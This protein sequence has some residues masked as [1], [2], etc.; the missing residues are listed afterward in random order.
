MNCE[1]AGSGPYLTMIHGAGNNLGIWSKQVS[2]LAGH[3]SVLTYDIRGNGASGSGSYQVTPHILVEDLRSLLEALGISSS[4]VLGHS[5]GA[6][7]AIRFYFDHPQMVDAIVICNSIMGALRSQRELFEMR[8]KRGDDSPEDDRVESDAD[9]KITRFFSPNLSQ[10]KPEVIAL[11]KEIVFGNRIERTPQERMLLNGIIGRLIDEPSP[12]AR[13]I[14][15]PTLV[16]NGSG[17]SLVRPS[18]VDSV[19][20]H[21]DN[22]RAETLD[23]GH[24]PFLEMPD[25][26]NRLIIGFARE[27]R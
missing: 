14:A 3:F 23:T 15:C 4:I 13:R 12:N 27:L 24:Y 9:D 21:F 6:E 20:H 22:I 7:I 5:M 18:V 8:I 16:I 10:R 26:F 1:L 2:E 25:E 19:G 11:Y 17:D